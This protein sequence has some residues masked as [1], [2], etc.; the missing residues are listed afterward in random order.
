MNDTVTVVK[1]YNCFLAEVCGNVFKG[2]AAG[3]NVMLLTLSMGTVMELN[4]FPR[5][6]VMWTMEYRIQQVQKYPFLKISKKNNQVSQVLDFI[7]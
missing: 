5:I 6:C 7:Q 4:V 3:V 2:V 1:N